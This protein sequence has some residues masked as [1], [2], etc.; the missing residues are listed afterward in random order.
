MT[1]LVLPPHLRGELELHAERGA[2][3][4]VCGLLVGARD[5]VE[6]VVPAR[7]RCAGRTTARYDLHPEDLLTAELEARAAGREVIG[8]Y[9]SHPRDPAVP[10][11]ADLE[12]AHPGWVYVIV[13]VRA[14]ET[15]AW[16]LAGQAFAEVALED[17]PGVTCNP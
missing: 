9:H 3:E 7:N 5:H 13:S 10:S 8:V 17:S 12:G 4:E 14:G 2:P 15:R 16:R 6:R 1:P 11:R